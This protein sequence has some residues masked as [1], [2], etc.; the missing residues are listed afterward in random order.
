MIH[1][2][3]A[4]LRRYPILG[5]GFGLAATVA[6]G[7]MILSGSHEARALLAQKRPVSL[8]PHDAVNQEGVRWVTV[9]GGHWRC[10]DAVTIPRQ[11][12]LERWVRGPVAATEVPIATGGGEELLVASFDGAVSCADRA[13]A[14]LT[15]VIGSVEVFTSRGAIGRWSRTGRRVAVLNVGAGPSEAR[16]LLLALVA[17]LLVAVLFSGYYL[18]LML[19]SR[20]RDRTAPSPSQPIEPS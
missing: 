12:M 3:P 19:R 4:T 1:I 2:D 9:T 16:F 8:S 11:G 5:V 17:L 15:G 18:T 14:P 13:G 6:F 10:E 20:D 7:F